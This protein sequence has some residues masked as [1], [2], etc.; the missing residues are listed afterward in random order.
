MK[1][2]SSDA[3]STS[4]NAGK[5]LLVRFRATQSQMGITRQVLTELA[6]HL[7]VTETVAIH[8]A[9]GQMHKE[10]LGYKRL[11]A[12]TVIPVKRKRTKT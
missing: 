12:I 10:L 5:S 2:E 3:S 4:I 6:E 8:M 1:T 11:E 7:G 9:V